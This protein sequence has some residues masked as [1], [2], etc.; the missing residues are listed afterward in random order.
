MYGEV[1]QE[2]ETSCPVTTLTRDP[3]SP[4]SVNISLENAPAK[5]THLI[6]N[7]SIKMPS[8]Y[9]YPHLHAFSLSYNPT[10]RAP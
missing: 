4:T 5:T 6:F 3:S 8:Y 10:C 1:R 9:R 2:K 7:A